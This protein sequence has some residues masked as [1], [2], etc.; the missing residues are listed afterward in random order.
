MGGIAGKNLGQ[1]RD[2]SALGDFPLENTN[3]LIGESHGGVIAGENEGMITGVIYYETV[4]RKSSATG[5]GR[6]SS[7]NPL[8]NQDEEA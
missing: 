7:L 1:V 5:N 8:K 6:E 3:N 2:G 4:G